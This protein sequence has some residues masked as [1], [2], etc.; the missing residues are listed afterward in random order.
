MHRSFTLIAGSL[1]SIVSLAAA[2]AAQ[3]PRITNGAVTAQPAGSPFAQSFRSLVA[4]Q[5]D[6]AWIGYSMPVVD[7]E[8]VMCCFQSGTTWINGDVVM[9]D[10]SNCCGACRLEPSA[11][12]TTFTSRAQTT[13]GPIKLEGS[14]RMVVLFRVAERR[15][16]RIRIFSE[17]CQLDA[18]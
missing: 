18:G 3:Q 17:D 10:R 11:D 5:P 2:V 1:A 6:I 9:G 8:R 16:D 7:A 13:G 14:D 15:L 4:S 12:G